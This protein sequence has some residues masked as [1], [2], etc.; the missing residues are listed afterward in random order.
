MHRFLTR[1]LPLVTLLPAVLL[2]A[3]AP[4]ALGAGRFGATDVMDVPTSGILND[5]A[6]GLYANAED[7]LTVLGMDFG[8]LPN[9]E[10]GLQALLSGGW[11]SA[12]LRLKYHLLSEK[13][14]GF[15]LAVGLQDIGQTFTT[16]YIV[17]G[18]TLGRGFQGY[19]GIGG[20]WLDGVF[21]ALTKRLDT[22]LGADLF[23]EYDGSGV[24][25]G[26]RLPLTPGLN[27][28]LGAPDLDHL[29][30]GVSYVSR[31]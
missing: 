22:S 1:T 11:T 9:L 6:F 19:L 12:G 15:G 13:R 10:A 17:A 4:A 21:F 24:N 16:P 28:D 30:V 14:D 3:C 26:A 27:L 18:K 25:A 8:L 7:G 23:L 29:V 2:L 5:G 20:G 31:F